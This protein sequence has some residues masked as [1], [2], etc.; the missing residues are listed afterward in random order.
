[1]NPL[2]CADI[3]IKHPKHWK[4][5]ESN[6]G[7][8]TTEYRTWSSIKERCR[9]NLPHQAR[10]YKSRGIKVCERWLG[11]DGYVNFLSDMGRRPKDKHSIDRIDSAKGY[12]PENCRWATWTEQQNNRSN[13][14]RITVDGVTKSL[15]DWCRQNG[16]PITTVHNRIRG[17]WEPAR[18]VTEPSH[19][20]R[21]LKGGEKFGSWMVEA[22]APLHNG[23]AA[24]YWCVCE[25]GKRKRVDA[26]GLV[27]GHRKRCRSCG[28]KGA[29]ECRRAKAR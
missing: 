11:E 18:A 27:S 13:T 15:M 26:Y 24:M 22:E 9:S 2:V 25:C 5:G 28:M 4:H 10:W 29:W 19:K 6:N 14:P 3:G 16:L 20:R 1:M 8:E 7:K 23:N 21:Q 12:S 17:G